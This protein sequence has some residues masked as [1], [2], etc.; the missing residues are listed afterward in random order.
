MLIGYPLGSAQSVTL[1]GTGA[2]FLNTPDGSATLVDDNPQSVARLGWLAISNNVITDYVAVR[3]TWPTAV[4]IR[5]GG[6]FGRN[7]LPAGLKLE[8]R[9]RES[10][11]SDF[12]LALGGNSLT[13]RTI[14]D[15]DGSIK[16]LWVFDDGLPNCTGAELRIFNDVNSSPTLD[17]DSYLDLGELVVRPAIEACVSPQWEWEIVDPSQR[18][19]TITSAQH[20]V[21]RRPYRAQ[22]L[23]IPPATTGKHYEGGLANGIDYRKLG[24]V[25]AGRATALVFPHWQDTAGNLDTT[26]LYTHGA[27]GNLTARP[28]RGRTRD[29][30]EQTWEFAEIPS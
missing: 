28:T 4:P 27:F 1:V 21:V 25:T 5:V 8:I 7:N 20:V 26:A 30:H 15:D 12:D 3:V 24:F 14:R 17:A 9:G 16:A 18:T 19:R 22:R 10:G 11:S 29:L 6:L 23:P 2:S 13:E